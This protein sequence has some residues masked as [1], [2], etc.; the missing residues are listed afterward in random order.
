MAGKV[1]L[2]IQKTCIIVCFLH[3][4]G[5][6]P[7]INRVDLANNA[8]VEFFDLLSQGNY[9]SARSYFGGSY[10]T[11]TYMNPDINPT[12]YENLWANACRNNGFVCLPVLKSTLIKIE[13]DLY[14]FEV[15][16]RRSDGGQFSLGACC[17]EDP[18]SVVPRTVFIYH[19]LKT[20]TGNYLVQDLP[21]YTP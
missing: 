13:G 15:E 5:C 19:V 3:L 10:E 20:E 18:A 12:D 14:T 1:A 17:G 2:I 6:T 4:G 21:V 8:L 11:L 7:S 9:Q 16:F